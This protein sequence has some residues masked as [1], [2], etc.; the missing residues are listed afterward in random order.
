[1]MDWISGKHVGK[2][3]REVP[4]S[5]EK[6]LHR[7]VLALFVCHFT[8]LSSK[9]P[10]QTSGDANPFAAGGPDEGGVYVETVAA[11]VPEQPGAQRGTATPAQAGQPP[12]H[13]QGA[14]GVPGPSRIVLQSTLATDPRAVPAFIGESGW[15]APVAV[16][17]TS[18]LAALSFAEGGANC[19]SPVY[20][21]D[22]TNTTV[23]AVMLVARGNLADLATLADAPET[24]RLRVV[25]EW[26]PEP[27]DITMIER[28]LTEAVTPGR[29]EEP[30][31]WKVLEVDFGEPADMAGLF[32]GGTAGEPVWV[33]GWRGE[34]AE[35]VAFDA[36]PDGDM[37]AGVANYLAIR[38][39][40]GG[41]PA[42]FAQRD[43]AKAAGLH[44]GVAWGSVLIIK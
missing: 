22:M 9:V 28:A 13:A 34:I 30:G 44:Y 14:S 2:L 36:P 10:Q 12:Q 39:G 7:A 17:V 1:M 19:P 41:Y 27:P 42:T 24:A 23:S 5:W 31:R 32:L 8:L 3:R 11:A 38:W 40:L 6:P 26:S 16:P 35:L 33:R 21:P 18:R 20:F 37:R 29:R 43:A 25:P 4:G 15:A